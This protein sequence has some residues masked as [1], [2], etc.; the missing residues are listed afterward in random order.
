MEMGVNVDLGL[1]DDQQIDL[2][3]GEGGK[4]SQ[5]P[6]FRAKALSLTTYPPSGLDLLL[7]QPRFGSRPTEDSS[8][9]D[10]SQIQLPQK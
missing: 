2:V 4:G 6:K 1:G 5:L 8:S 10:Q 7:I 9:L 3:S